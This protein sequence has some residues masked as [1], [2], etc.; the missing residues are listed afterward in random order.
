MMYEF[1]AE[2]FADAL[3]TMFNWIESG[4]MP[5]QN[6]SMPMRNPERAGYWYVQTANWFK[7]VEK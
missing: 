2:S 6:Y 3:E 7:V 1:M 4:I 5:K